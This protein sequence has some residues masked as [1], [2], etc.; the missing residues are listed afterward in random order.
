LDKIPD[1]TRVAVGVWSRFVRKAIDGGHSGEKTS[2]FREYSQ[3]TGPQDPPYYPKRLAADKASLQRYRALAESLANGNTVASKLACPVSF[4]GRLA[5]YRYLDM[6]PVIGEALSFAESFIT[7][8]KSGSAAP[9]FSNT[10][11]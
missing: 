9:I 8:R 5:T 10:E 3:E 11:P 4:L 6:G 1:Q 2:A 7:S